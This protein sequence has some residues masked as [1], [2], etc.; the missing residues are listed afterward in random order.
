MED[1]KKKFHNAIK[2]YQITS[3][4]RKNGL[5]KYSYE[6][7]FE[8]KLAQFYSKIEQKFYFAISEPIKFLKSFFSLFK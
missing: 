5:R 8:Y 3:Y 4:K 2:Y 7:T 6:E 1:E